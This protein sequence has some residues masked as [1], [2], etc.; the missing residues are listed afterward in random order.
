MQFSLS[1]ANLI[2]LAFVAM[3]ITETAAAPVVDS[4]V[5]EYEL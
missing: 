3:T 1:F 5:V 2:V 4:S